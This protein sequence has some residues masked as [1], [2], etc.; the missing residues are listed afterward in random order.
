MVE[1]EFL[2]QQNT[3]FDVIL[4]FLES[5]DNPKYRFLQLTEGI[6]KHRLGD[7]ETITTIPSELRKE[8][9]ERFSPILSITPI[10]IEQSRQVVKILFELR[11]GERIETVKMEFKG[12][13]NWGS[14]CISSQVGCG[15]GCV[16]CATGKIGLK[17]N[18]T[19]D[20]I[21]DQP[22]YF[23]LRG[24]DI[25]SI[26]F[27]GMG[28]PLLNPATFVAIRALTNKD[29]FGFSQRKISVS[30]IGIVPGIKKLTEEFPQINIAFSIQTPFEEQ[31]RELMPIAKR[32][33]IEE[34]MEVLDEHVRR[35]KRKIFLAYTMLKGINDSQAHLEALRDLINNR[36]QISYLYHVNLIRYNPIF[37]EKKF[38]CTDDKLI[39]W[40]K[41]EL[42]KSGI[43]V[44]IRQSFGT[45]IHGACGQLR[46]DYYG[47]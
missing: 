36:G 25:H 8:L 4:N 2:N 23:H 16:Y 9:K 3:K 35:N 5:K 10:K 45:E 27:M 26:S 42:N 15:L 24:D 6:F 40:F 38:Q 33:S 37:G 11:D 21:I 39:E 43:N 14:L 32:Y 17:R 28:E 13:R 22:L 29:L 47:I 12:K 31:R 30:T 7:F 41:E 19:P 34:I 44:T 46:A 1:K 18:L 20:E